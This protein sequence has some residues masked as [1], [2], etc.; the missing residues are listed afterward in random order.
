[1]PSQTSNT[2]EN[3]NN[4]LI[5][6][7]CD[8]SYNHE[9][10][11]SF[12][13]LC[14]SLSAAWVKNELYYNRLYFPIIYKED[15]E[16]KDIC[17]DLIA[18][19]FERDESNSFVLFRQ[20]ISL[21]DYQLV[22][23]S[24]YNRLKSIII[25]KTRQE[26][27]ERFKEEEP[28][29]YKILR[30]I[31]LSPTRKNN[32]KKFDD[33]YNTYLYYLKGECQEHNI[34]DHLRAK[35]PQIEEEELLDLVR[36]V[37][38]KYATIPKIL[39]NILINIQKNNTCSD[40]V[41]ISSLFKAIKNV[42]LYKTVQFVSYIENDGYND[43][44]DDFNTKILQE[45]DESIQLTVKEKYIN[46]NKI[47]EN[48]ANY[49]KLVLKEYFEDMILAHGGN[50]PLPQYLYNEHSTHIPKDTF[51]QHKTRIEYLIKILKKNIE[52]IIS[53]Y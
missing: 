6:R 22:D 41:E 28:G 32:I 3:I 8:G 37:C 43:N 30:N 13:N 27:I 19:L 34:L 31:K 36:I 29:G 39:E 47:D 7:I 35:L 51:V 20:N 52:Q 11:I 14:T 48:V 33:Q 5:I 4:L 12:V 16:L 42:M 15:H 40:F 23:N 9:D 24:L 2:N 21:D 53:K 44:R 10:L 38:K 17:L 45:L 1:M 50:N 26:L 46:T 25:S 18:P 49:Y